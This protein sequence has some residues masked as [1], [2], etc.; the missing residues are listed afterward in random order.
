MQANEVTKWFGAASHV[1][2]TLA[3]DFAICLSLV[4]VAAPSAGQSPG[5]IDTHSHIL[6]AGRRGPDFRG[7]LDAAIQR[8][9][10]HGIRRIIVMPPP[11]VDRTYEIESYRFANQ[12]YAGRILL[13]GGGGSLNVM[14]QTT[15]P[16]A[17]TDN[18]KNAF[19]AHAEQI[20]AAGAAVFGEIALHHL[21]LRFSGPQHPYEWIP[22]GSSTTAAARGHRCRKE[23][24]NRR[25]YGPCTRGHE[26]PG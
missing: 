3:V 22:L 16:D 2:R 15:A 19:R 10:Q 6:N 17:V 20:I 12:A 26:S 7:S 14:I 13:G 5:F 23:H 21:S 25:P 18:V 1:L 4:L 11:M 8:M 9:N 24:P